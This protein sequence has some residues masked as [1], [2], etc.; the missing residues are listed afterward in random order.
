MKKALS[1]V[2]SLLV[3]LS[4]FGMVSAAEEAE[5]TQPAYKPGVVTIKFMNG[6]T[7]YR[8]IKV[9]PETPFVNRLLEGSEALGIPEKKDPEG[10]I[11]Y[12]F[13]GWKNEATGEVRTTGGIPMVEKQLNEDGT[14]VENRVITYIAVYA[15]KDIVANQTFWAFIQTIFA[16]INMIFEY[17]AK[18]F[19]G[20][21]D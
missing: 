3:I 14:P 16:R 20:A 9:M 12:I 21:F 15:E 1:V 13:E 4:M 5:A 11:E 7:L 2:L 6:E 8:E 19:E 18:I 10:K 17:F